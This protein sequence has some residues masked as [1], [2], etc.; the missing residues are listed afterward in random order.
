L[1]G[2]H[3]RNRGP[4]ASRSLAIVLFGFLGLV[5][6]IPFR[7]QQIPPAPVIS[8]EV[9]SD[10]RVTF[11]LHAPNTKEV[12]VR[13]EGRKDPL[14]MQKDDQ[15][16]WSVATAALQPDFYSYIF[17]ADGVREADPSN[18]AVIP[19][20]LISE[21]V[22]HVP[23][24]P[25]LPWEINDVPHGVV[26]HHFYRSHVIGDNRDFFVYTPPGYDSRG[27]KSFPVLYLLHGFGQTADSWVSI[28]RANVIL[29][30]LIAQSKAQ[31]MIVVMPLGYGAPEMLKPGAPRFRDSTLRDQNVT[32]FRDSLVAEVIPAVELNYRAARDRNSRAI[33]GLSMG[34]GEA[35]YVGLSALDRFAWIGAFSQCCLE[36]DHQPAGSQAKGSTFD[37]KDRASLRL[38]WVSG[39]K[40][41]ELLPR[42]EKL[43]DALQAQGF[44]VRWV[45]TDGAHEWPV[46]RRNLAEFAPLLFQKR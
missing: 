20:F 36:D 27:K 35:A 2:E 46:W 34:G 41:D 30:N 42:S 26:H 10:N 33:A 40:D 31:P 29:D 16:V 14:A 7:A 8:P 17:V 3:L 45:E 18:P 24:P 39:G 12:T 44:S 37:A 11:R 6:S 23:G 9:S 25:A 38:L 15:G 28:G 5:P 19:N 4:L 32:K 1:T 13:I 43:R 22:V 21:S